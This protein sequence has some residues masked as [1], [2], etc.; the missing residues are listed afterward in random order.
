M[1]MEDSVKKIKI[2]QGN[3]I[4]IKMHTKHTTQYPHRSSKSNVLHRDFYIC[5]K[6]P[7]QWIHCTDLA[8]KQYSY[9]E[10]F[11]RTNFLFFLI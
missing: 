8:H 3:I 11:S 1:N 2:E 6:Y 4:S 9:T 5:R 10:F 7:P